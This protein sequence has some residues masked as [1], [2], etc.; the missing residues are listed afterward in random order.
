MAA[1][2]SVRILHLSDLYFSGERRWDTDP[3]LRGLGE[4]VREMAGSGL[5]PDLVAIT[6]DIAFAGQGKDFAAAREGIAALLEALPSAIPPE[7]LLLVPG[8]HD[9]DRRAVNDPSGAPAFLALTLMDRRE[10]NAD[11]QDEKA[12]RDR[13]GRRREVQNVIAAHLQDP[14]QHQTLLRPLAGYMAFVNRYRAEGEHLNVPWWSRTLD[15]RGL[16]VHVAGLCSV[17]MS[18]GSDD[19]GRLLVGRWQAETLLAGAENSALSIALIHHP[20]S[21]L[22]PFDAAEVAPLVHDKCD[23]VLH[24]HQHRSYSRLVPGR[25]DGCLELAASFSSA[26]GKGSRAFQLVQYLPERRQ[27]RVHHR[28]W[29]NGK[30]E[31]DSSIHGATSEGAVTINLRSASVKRATV[32]ARQGSAQTP[33]R[34]LALKSIRSIETLDLSFEQEARKNRRWT[35]LLGE[36]GCGKTTLLRAVALLMSGSEALGELIGDVDDWIRRNRN[37]AWIEAELGGLGSTPRTLRLTFQRGATLRQFFDQNRT[38]LDR[39]DRAIASDQRN[40]FTVGY[41]CSRRLSGKGAISP[42]DSDTF[43]NPRAQCVATLFSVDAR[44][45]PLQSWALDLHYRE[46]ERGLA[47]I[48]EVFKGLLPGMKFERIDPRRRD[49]VF[50]TPDGELT[51]SQLSD[52]YQ[53]MAAWCGDLLY[54][55]TS[56]SEEEDQ[57]LSTS[58]LLLIDEVDLHLHPIWQRKLRAFLNEKLPNYQILAT[59]H[60]PLTAQQAEE[61]ELYTLRRPADNQPAILEEYPGAPCD[62]L[63]DQLITSP[64]IGVSSVHSPQVEEI[65]QEYRDLRDK[66]RKT[67]QDRNRLARLREQLR[68]RPDPSRASQYEQQQIAILERVS[69][70]LGREVGDPDD[71]R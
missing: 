63:I 16:R 69:E 8:N 20:W 41:G 49:L 62:L 59:T 25:A 44:L 19:W 12:Q 10:L 58:G 48:E 56:L 6:G 2:P 32:P 17:W 57:P 22:E 21:W 14:K 40:F 71:G 46:Q 54:R 36:N 33:L 28:L 30:W 67:P 42:A 53:T 64:A 15:V 7:R 5:E 27:M 34:R 29:W 18:S 39:I 45:N 68:N 13:D 66:Q 43:S 24:G 61:G 11:A 52:G 23:L 70:A 60:S 31:P 37:E 55:V 51:L 65:R 4:A 26:S 50:A 38:A 1:E 35:L 3:A 9:I 47:V